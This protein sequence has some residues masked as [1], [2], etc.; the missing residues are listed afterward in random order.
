MVKAAMRLGFDMTMLA[1]ESQQVI[2]LRLAQLAMGGPAASREARR[3]VSEKAA[4]AVETGI[5]LAAGGGPHKVVGNY[6][7]KVR[8]NRDRLV[9]NM[10]SRK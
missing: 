6:R 1:I 4:A 10:L 3:M 7:K 2:A 9:S 5:H 8:A